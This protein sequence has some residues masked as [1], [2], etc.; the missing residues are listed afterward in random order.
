MFGDNMSLLAFIR[1][2]FANFSSS[3]LFSFFPRLHQ[4]F[5]FLFSFFPPIND[6]IF[7][8]SITKYRISHN[9]VRFLRESVRDCGNNNKEN[10]TGKRINRGWKKATTA[11]TRNFTCFL[12]DHDIVANSLIEFASLPFDG[13]NVAFVS[14]LSRSSGRNR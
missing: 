5:F 6:D 14:P 8:R 3:F 9:F 7:D 11:A 12:K 1:L 4:N 13:H 2:N 10:V